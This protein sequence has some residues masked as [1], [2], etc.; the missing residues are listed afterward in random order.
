[1]R[2][3]QRRWTGWAASAATLA[4]LLTAGGADAGMPPEAMK[5]ILEAN[6]DAVLNLTGGLKYLCAHCSKVH[7]REARG[8]GTIV[9]PAGLMVVAGFH[10]GLDLGSGKI[11][12]RESQ[13]KAVLPDGRELAMKI[14]LTDPDLG[15]AILAPEAAAQ[16]F[17][18]V[19]WDPAVKAELLDD[20]LVVGRL[21]KNMGNQAVAEPG[22][23]NAVDRKP[24]T[25]YFSNIINLAGDAGFPCFTAEGRL[26]GLCFGEQTLIATGE[27]Q[28]LLDQARQVAAKSKPAQGAPAQ[29]GK[30]LSP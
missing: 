16:P 10:L 25:L 20:V 17:K 29:A 21:D 26:L 15:L 7:E 8:C 2:T 27:L 18:A 9:D 30:G 14:L 4:L 3:K 12:I 23:I 6:Q 22:K 5:K 24:R 19:P 1:M 13:L 28:D 11:D